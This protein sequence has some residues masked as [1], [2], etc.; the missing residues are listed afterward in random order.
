MNV[1]ILIL[2]GLVMFFI[3]SCSGTYHAY[4]QT[5]KIAFI[6]KEDAKI[7]IEEVKQSKIDI[8]SVKRGERPKAIM[9]LAY[10][11][12]DKH[13][14]VS[15]DNVMLTM[16]KGRII[17][18]LGLSDNLIYLSSTNPDPLK[19]LSNEVL[20]KEV[21]R[22]PTWSFMIDLAGDQYGHSIESIFK[23]VSK[24]TITVLGLDTKS[25]LYVENL[26]YITPSNYIRL[27]KSWKNYYWYSD[28]GELIKSIQKISPLSELLEVTYLSR[29]ARLNQ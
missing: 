3:S 5:L 14:W 22:Q 11:E 17:R 6:K 27:N 29:I 7:T 16:E 20:T 24:D 15:S 2:S 21:Q 10:L 4:Y 13:K 8:I 23:Y 9:A 25:V 18:T 19:L 12:N 1:K 28:S 26:N